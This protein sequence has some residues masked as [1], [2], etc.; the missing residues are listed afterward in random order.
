ML[1]SKLRSLIHMIKDKRLSIKEEYLLYLSEVPKH[2]F[3]CMAVKISE[4]TSKRWRDEDRDFADLCEQ[5]ISAW[6]RKT[7]KKTK[8][9]F[10]LERL[11]REDF[12]QR[13]EITG[14]EGRDLPVPIYNG[15]SFTSIDHD[16]SKTTT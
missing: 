6:V 11:M 10:Q 15:L 14:K 8:P 5:N 7:L 4:D 2:K 1:F 16:T 3:A 13:A 12:S 9:E